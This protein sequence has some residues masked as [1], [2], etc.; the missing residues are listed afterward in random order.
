MCADKKKTEKRMEV[1]RN[2]SKFNVNMIFIECGGMTSVYVS[3]VKLADPDSREAH[4]LRLRRRH[5]HHK[6]V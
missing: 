2:N 5:T 3:S 1:Y 4:S 6:S